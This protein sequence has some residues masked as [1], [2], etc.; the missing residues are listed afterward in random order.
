[1]AWKPL[2]PSK[3]ET[4]ENESLWRQ[5]KRCKFLVDENLG[6]GTAWL[7]RD[8]WKANVEFVPDVGLSGKSDMDASAVVVHDAASS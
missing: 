5:Q 1:M 2:I 4:K 3:K 7:L 8:Q 6:K